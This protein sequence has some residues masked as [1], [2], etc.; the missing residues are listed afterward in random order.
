MKLLILGLI[1]IGILIMKLYYINK[2]GFVDETNLNL[3]KKIDDEKK[4]IKNQA[5]NYIIKS[6]PPGE[7]KIKSGIE[8]VKPKREKVI[9]GYGSRLLLDVVPSGNQIL[10]TK[11]DKEIEMCNIITDCKDLPDKDPTGNGCG[12]CAINELDEVP[13]TGQGFSFGDKNNTLD[14][15]SCK[16]GQ[17]VRNKTKCQYLS[18]KQQCAKVKSCGDLIGGLEEICGWC[19]TRG[20]S[21]PKN[22]GSETLMFPNE[23]ICPSSGQFE[24]GKLLTSQKCGAFLDEHPCITPY[25]QSGPHSGKCVKKLWELSGCKPKGLKNQGAEKGINIDDYVEKLGDQYG[26]H[27]NIKSYQQLGKDFQSTEKLINNNTY[28]I[29]KG[30]SD[31]CLGDSSKLNSC[32]SKYNTNGNPDIECLKK[33]YLESGCTKEGTGW[34]NLNRGEIAKKNHIEDINTFNKNQYEE[35]TEGNITYRKGNNT[36]TSEAYLENLLSLESLTVNA[37]D[38]STRLK[39]SKICYGKIPPPPPGIKKGDAVYR[40]I[41]NENY[42]GIATDVRIKDGRKAA[43]VMWYKKT[44]QTTKVIQ[45]RKNQTDIEKMYFGWPGIAP[46]HNKMLVDKD[47]WII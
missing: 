47:G 1:L 12:Y 24:G 11:E 18:A 45:E 15:I 22:P 16:K 38:Y 26:S 19:P 33:K 37:E 30:A 34:K 3:E 44:H 31:Y 39:T 35:D 20:I 7:E 25:H 8:F 13:A 14:D 40:I 29:A 28:S 43:L 42:E 10:K 2:E 17:W 32:D 46:T 27:P 5:R 4:T 21:L 9:E 23:D 6:S 36:T 41:N